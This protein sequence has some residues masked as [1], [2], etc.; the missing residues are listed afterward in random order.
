[1]VP[2]LVTVWKL[3]MLSVPALIRPSFCRLLPAPVPVKVAGPPL[4]L[5]KPPLL[6]VSKFLTVSAL[7]GASTLR[8]PSL[9][10]ES[11]PPAPSKVASPVTR[12]M[13]M[14]AFSKSSAPGV[15][16]YSRP[17]LAMIL[18][19]L[20]TVSKFWIWVSPAT[21]NVLPADTCSVSASSPPSTFRNWLKVRL[22]SNDRPSSPACMSTVLPGMQVS[23]LTALRLSPATV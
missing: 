21:L 13:P 8:R 18:P 10:K 7:P 15:P 4:V 14:A 5:M 1:M 11:T 19:S 2:L 20:L 9:V 23:V 16:L 6:T 3:L 22:A 12:I 17:P